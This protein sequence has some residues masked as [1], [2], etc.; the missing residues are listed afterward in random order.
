MD[1]RIRLPR[2]NV[3]CFL[4][5][6]VLVLTILVDFDGWLSI[7]LLMDRVLDWRG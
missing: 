7:V 1:A 6:L 4:V 3:G 2:F 5:A